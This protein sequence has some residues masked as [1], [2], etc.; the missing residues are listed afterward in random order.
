MATQ[1]E[2]S[3]H[4]YPQD[5][6]EWAKYLQ[7]KLGERE[8]EI[9]IALNDV[10]S[11]CTAQGRN[12]INV[13]L[14]TPDFLDLKDLNFMTGFD[15]QFSLAILMGVD[16]EN[17]TSITTQSGVHEDVKDWLTLDVD[18]TEESVRHLI[19]TIVSMYEYDYP[20]PRIRPI[21]MEVID[22][23]ITKVFIGLEKKAESDVFV[24]FYGNDETLKAS[25]TNRYF[26]NFSL[27]DE[28]AETFSTFSVMCKER[29]IGQGQLKY[30]VHS[31]HEGSTSDDDL[32]PAA[33]RVLGGTQSKLQ[34][35]WELLKEETD[36][37]NLLCLSMGLCGSDREQL[38]R[39]LANK[40]SALGFPEHLSLMEIDEDSSQ[41]KSERKWPTL[42]HFA[43]EY[44][45]VGFA[46]ALLSYPAFAG[47]IKI[48][49]YEGRTPDEIAHH[50]GHQELSE[51][52]K[53]FSYCIFVVRRWS[54]DNGFGDKVR[55]SHIKSYVD[56]MG[57][58]EGSQL[59]PPP[60]A[61]H[62]RSN[63]REV[64]YV[65]PPR[66][67]PVQ[68]MLDPSLGEED[69]RLDS[70]SA[71]NLTTGEDKGEENDENVKDKLEDLTETMHKHK[72]DQ[73]TYIELQTDHVAMEEML[74]V[75]YPTLKE[76]F[77]QSTL[78]EGKPAESKI[79]QQI[80]IR[81]MQE[82]LKHE[83]KKRGFLSKLFKRK[84][85]PSHRNRSFSDG[86]LDS[87]L[88]FR[89]GKRDVC[90]ICTQYEDPVERE[91][92]IIRSMSVSSH[93]D[94]NGNKQEKGKVHE[95]IK[96]KSKK[97]MHHLLKNAEFRKSLR[98][99]HAKRDTNI[100]GPSVP[101]KK[102]GHS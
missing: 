31:S 92:D 46:E 70:R 76:E 81:I 22:E 84:E 98:L 60:P 19:M 56:K 2:I 16:I 82:T 55:L 79:P 91:S 11:D 15:H 72:C 6:V 80:D 43:A 28:E 18:G 53:L 45:L 74:F 87:V 88:E 14:I 47:A 23:G 102:I 57:S 36:P 66:P 89:R 17:Y 3:I 95:E 83:A 21:F 32:T 10:T 12:R 94:T 26:Y 99:A 13:F 96:A 85:K 39:E 73:E 67:R 75:A 69:E 4:Y 97:K 29:K 9:D 59:C 54:N 64:G 68:V 58:S 8:Y 7:V 101:S 37:I 25:Y 44:N 100:S 34:Q 78:E 49:N 90:R 41:F 5:G 27:T 48:K 77:T 33:S 62:V 51:M 71:A 93:S 50:S 1:K 35:L 86:I 42:L 52:L 40:I 24:K 61:P 30:L 65:R 38:D 63:V 20:P